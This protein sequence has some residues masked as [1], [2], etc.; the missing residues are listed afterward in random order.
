MA[1]FIPWRTQICVRHVQGFVPKKENG[2]SGLCQAENG[3][4]PAETEVLHSSRSSSYSS[5][6]RFSQLKNTYDTYVENE[7]WNE[8]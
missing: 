6:L 4:N 2:W 8:S 3:P 7:V 1:T 5:R